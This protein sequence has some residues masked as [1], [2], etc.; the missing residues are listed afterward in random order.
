M[1]PI[2]P[3]PPQD[4]DE[5]VPPVARNKYVKAIEKYILLRTQRGV[6]MPA[7]DMWVK[8]A[9]TR[10]CRIWQ[11]GT[12]LHQELNLARVESFQRGS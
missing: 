9:D 7:A 1:T 4:R 11:R 10:T 2:P 3:T 6:E 5:L 8:K 12:A